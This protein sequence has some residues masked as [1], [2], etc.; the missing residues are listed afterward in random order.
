MSALIKAYYDSVEVAR[1][2]VEFGADVTS[3]NSTC[4]TAVVVAGHFGSANT[5]RYLIELGADIHEK[6][7][8][9]NLR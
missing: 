5:A 9:G 8:Y 2:L 4:E 6:E 3:K 1:Y 7:K